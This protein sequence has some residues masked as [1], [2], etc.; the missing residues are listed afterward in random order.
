[1]EQVG[2][3]D[4]SRGG[5]LV[6]RY[7]LRPRSQKH[8]PFY[9]AAVHDVMDEMMTSSCVL[10][11]ENGRRDGEAPNAPFCGYGEGG[12]GG[13]GGEDKKDEENADYGWQ[14]SC[15]VL[16]DGTMID[17]VGSRAGRDFRR[18]QVSVRTP[19]QSSFPLSILLRRVSEQTFPLCE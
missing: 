3:Q 5:G 10:P 15:Y 18:L 19:S 14:D 1:M 6:A 4:G 2:R 12:G 7:L 16:L 13:A 8:L 17:L 11:L 9:F